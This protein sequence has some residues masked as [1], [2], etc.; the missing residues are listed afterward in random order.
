M[1]APGCQIGHQLGER[2]RVRLGWISRELSFHGPVRRYYITRNRVLVFREYAW[3]F[4]RWSVLMAMAECRGLL[5]NLI[6]GRERALQLVA[7]VAGAWDGITGRDGKIP[8]SLAAR[9]TG[10]LD[11]ASPRSPS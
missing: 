4:R 8:G 11:I 1:E 9:L 7:I 10:E 3:G 2:R 6:F 5:K